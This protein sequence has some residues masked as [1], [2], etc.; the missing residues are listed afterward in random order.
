MITTTLSWIAEQVGGQLQGEDLT[1]EGVSTDTRTIKPG[2]VYLALIG[3]NF[4]GHHFAEAAEKAG[5]AAVIASE[6]VNSAVPVIRV[7]D[8]RIALGLLGAAVKRQV[9]PKTIAITGSSGKTTVK[10]MTAAILARRGTVLATAGNFNNEIGVPLTLLRLEPQHDFAV[11]ELGAN[12]LGEIAYTVDLVKPDVATIVNAAAS[13]LEG[14]GSLLGV[15][16]AKSEIFKGLDKNGVAIVNADSQFTNFWLGKLRHTNVLTFA[17]KQEQPADFYAEDICI[18]LDGCAEFQLVCPQGQIG[19]QLVIPGSHNVGNALVAAALALQVGATLEDVRDGLLSMTQVKGRLNVKRL[20]DQVRL[21]DD[22]YNANV[23]SVNAAID[24]LA[25]FSGKRVLV[26][27]D[28]AELGEKSRYYHEQVGQYALEKG[29]DALFTLGVLS[30]SASAVFSDQGQHFS[31]VEDLVAQLETTLMS[32][33]RDIS[34]LVKGSRSSKMERVVAAI[35]ASPL[36]KLDSRR[37]RIA[38]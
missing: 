24:T 6:P 29:I 31:S 8:T 25:G 18:G 12:H 15:A 32:E 27:G 35:E 21:L 1:I 20:T 36:G 34:I 22:T 23:A 13:H 4:N 19:I 3:D 38:C 33:Q 16:R 7:E 30:Q 26:L 10:E 5:A 14:F 11:M 17:P 2:D 9:A 37:E 28:M